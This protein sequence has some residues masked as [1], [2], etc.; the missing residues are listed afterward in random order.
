MI[1][2]TDDSADDVEVEVV[3]L[4]RAHRF[5]VVDAGGAVRAVLG[6]LDTPDPASPVF[7]LSLLDGDGRARVWLSIDALGPALVFDL[8]GNNLITLGVNDPAA[9]A[10]RVGG[11]FHMADFDGKTVFGWQLGDDGTVLARLGGAR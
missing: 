8:A 5:E 2:P 10:L 9:D 7:G 3:D 1:D 4:V 6:S 11:Y